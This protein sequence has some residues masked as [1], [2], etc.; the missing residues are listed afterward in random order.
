MLWHLAPTSPKFRRSIFH[1]ISPCTTLAL[2]FPR[3]LRETREK[4]PHQPNI[5]LPS[6]FKPWRNGRRLISMNEAVDSRI[7]PVLCGYFPTQVLFS[8]FAESSES[9]SLMNS[10]RNTKDHI[11]IHF[12]SDFFLS[13]AR[14]SGLHP[15]SNKS[16]MP[17]EITHI[18][19]LSLA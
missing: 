17:L 4:C 9:T 6:I 19:P 10:V 18:Q 8:F 13:I 14:L 3:I 15:S 2:K 16:T 12:S 11:N 1:S 7:G 5:K